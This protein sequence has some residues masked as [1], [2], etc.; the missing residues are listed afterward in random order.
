MRTGA[1]FRY[2]PASR[3]G[4]LKGACAFS[5]IA[6]NWRGG[7]QSLLTRSHRSIET[8][9][10]LRDLELPIELCLGAINFAS[11][12]TVSNYI[13]CTSTAVGN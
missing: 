12:L 5:Q 4:L 9:D 1:P 2:L 6:A 3:A 11:H 10:L 8:D 13:A 7:E